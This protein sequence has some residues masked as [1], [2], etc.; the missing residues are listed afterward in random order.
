MTQVSSLLSHID[1]A[2]FAFIGVLA[3]ASW[4]RRRGRVR[5]C[6]AAA[7]GL[8]G[9]VSAIGQVTAVIHLPAFV[10]II[11]LVCFMASGYAL[12]ELRHNLIPLP[13]RARPMLLVIL[14][15]TTVLALPGTLSAPASTPSRYAWIVGSALILE[16]AACI[17]EP[18][19]RFWLASRDRP[20]VQRKRLRALSA[21]YFGIAVA[22]VLALGAAVGAAALS[23]RPNAAVG[24]AF[25]LVATA[26]IPLFYVGFAPP[27]WLRRSWRDREAHEYR[28]ANDALMT[29]ADDRAAIARQAVEWAT[30][31]VGASAG[32]MLDT[33]G[34]VLAT[35]GLSGPEIE[36]L[37]SRAV[38]AGVGGAR[39][40]GGDV[41]VA[42]VHTAAGQATMVVAAGPFTPVFGTDEIGMLN[43]F[44][45]SLAIAM[46]RVRFSEELRR[47]T[48]R[49]ESLLQAVSELGAGLLI[50][51]SGRLIYANEA[52]ISM[53]GYLYDELD[54]RG[55]VELAPEGERDDLRRRLSAHL[56]GTSLPQ[57]SEA[58]LIRK[59]GR[60]L[61]V[62]A[63]VHRLTNEGPDRLISLVQDI[64]SRKQAELALADAA[65]LDPLTGVPNR[66]AWRE[67]LASCIA[68]AARHDEPLSVAVLD[69]DNFK[70]FNDDWGHQRGDRL[71]IDVAQAW[72][73][74]LR[75]GDFIARYGGDEFSLIM[76]ATTAPQAV[77]ALQR[78]SDAT[79]ERA[80]AGIA[81]WAGDESAEELVARADMALLR[82]KKE[83]RGSVT[84]AGERPEDQFAGWTNRLDQVMERR[85]LTAAYQP[86]VSL[87]SNQV[88]GYEGLLR[89]A[90]AA[91]DSSVEELFSAAQRLG[92]SRDL[93]WLGRRAALECSRNLPSDALLFVNVSARALLDPMHATDQ[94]LMLLRWADRRPED[95]VLEISEREM[96]SDLARLRQVLCDYRAH[97]FR[98][99]L[100]DVGEGHSTLELLAAANAEYIKIARSL[101]ERVEQPGPGSAVRAIVTFAESSGATIVA[102]GISELSM[103]EAMRELGVKYGQGFALGRPAFVEG[104]PIAE[105][106]AEAV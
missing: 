97:G 47:Q 80:S 94:M 101:T 38:E 27:G 3:L 96:I 17:I 71:L 10:A 30:R 78:L 4:I 87:A 105:A 31:F 76:P 100:D 82:C 70:E 65:R 39:L 16:W 85:Y 40:L 81:Q 88:L 68:H 106:A 41:A 23:A 25:Q 56:S 63:V 28:R 74:A 9:F 91:A 57:R 8:L 15:V 5:A 26:A 45:N 43:G 104:H 69:L 60:V 32:L 42:P 33:D 83:R 67:Q 1:A 21:G 86:I 20:V 72:K 102:E 13:R 64:S 55:L 19:I 93:D 90:G 11:N 77:T 62:E 24:L 37:A 18:A 59:D 50:T 29:F 66:R 36:Q 48:E 92:Y 52:Y 54:G 6:L 73:S 53:T 99:A 2:G 79:P 61:D 35:R 49:M 22:L 51:E 46:D 98:F 75:E 14:G 84:V 7:L 12:V 34:T 103:A 58:R 44:A 95:V 89:L